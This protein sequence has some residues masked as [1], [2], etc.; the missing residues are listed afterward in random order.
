MTA[1][2]SNADVKNEWSY[3]STPPLCFHGMRTDGF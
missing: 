2:Q 3:S 1:P